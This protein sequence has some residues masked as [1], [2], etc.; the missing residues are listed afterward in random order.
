MC[1]RDRL[2][3]EPAAGAEELAL[4]PQPASE[5]A[6]TAHARNADIIFFM[7][8]PL[9]TPW[10]CK[11][12]QSYFSLKP[13]IFKAFITFAVSYTHL[14]VYKRQIIKRIKQ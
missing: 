3:A 9:F 5:S 12:L 11:V 13:Y 4:P 14:D 1:I 10:Y 2:E 6:M 8:V 7:F